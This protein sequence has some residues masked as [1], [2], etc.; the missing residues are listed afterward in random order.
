MSDP[1]G[2]RPFPRGALFGALAVVVITVAAA[3]AGRFTDLGRSEAP[4]AATV[5][6]HDLYFQ[7][8]NDGAVEVLDA[9]KGKVILVLEP[10]T[11]GFVRGV[12]RGLVRDRKLREIGPDTPFQLV[13]W[14]DGRL[15]L[16]DPATGREI[17]LGAFGPTNLGAF[18]RI[19]LAAEETS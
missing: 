7:D 17:D 15:T 11:N 16:D 19:L 12:M 5:E 4:R 14:D 3:G 8:R 10:G 2:D 1:F 9:A 18:A 13:R 6:S